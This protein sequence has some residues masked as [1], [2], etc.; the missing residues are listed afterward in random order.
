MAGTARRLRIAV[1]GA[2]MVGRAHAL[3]FGA[4]RAFVHPLPVDVQLAVVADPQESL[5]RE[6]QARHGFERIAPSWREV[7]EAPDVDA[8]CVALPNHQHRAAVE[9]FVAGGKHVLCEKPLA[10][11]ARDANAM[12][13]AAR[14][15]GVVHGVGFSQRRAPAGPGVPRGGPPRAPGRA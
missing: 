10:L 9:A 1:V 13:L 15:A 3:A 2:G 12:L 8:V 4:L 7:A 6:A 5:A 11:S 14:R